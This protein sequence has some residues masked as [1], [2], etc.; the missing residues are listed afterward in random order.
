MAE[1]RELVA[2]RLDEL[3]KERDQMGRNLAGVKDLVKKVALGLAE[4]RGRVTKEGQEM[5]GWREEVEVRLDSLTEEVNSWEEADEGAEKDKGSKSSRVEDL[6][7]VEAEEASEEEEPEGSESG[8][9][10]E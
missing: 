3:E 1:W 2:W 10:S 9:S 5:T 7:D 4:V 8:E 6:L